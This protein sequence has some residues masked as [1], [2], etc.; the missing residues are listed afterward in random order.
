[1]ARNFGIVSSI[2]LSDDSEYS[3][4]FIPH[5]RR[6]F[7]CAFYSVT[8]L[9]TQHIEDLDRKVNKL[10][11]ITGDSKSSN[12][13]HL[14]ES[15]ESMLIPCRT[16]PGKEAQSDPVNECVLAFRVFPGDSS[17]ALP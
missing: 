14:R 11:G 17:G 15:E 6:L 13:I 9:T 10:N 3:S 1:M 12:R 7:G 4:N 5:L 16:E 2:T 8:S